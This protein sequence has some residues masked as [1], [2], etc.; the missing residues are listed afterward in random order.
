M[1]D[2]V[3]I[4]DCVDLIW[5]LLENPDVGGICNVGSGT[6]RTWNDLAAAVFAAM[7]RPL[8]INY[9]DMP[10][11]LRGKY[12]YFTEAD[13]GWLERKE[14]PLAFHSLEDGVRDYV[15]NYLLADDPY[16]R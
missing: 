15:R 12:Q 6:A 5:W 14:C 8:S 4:K 10:E 3:Y 16:L 2:F 13:M 7:G 11:A 9:I 1:R